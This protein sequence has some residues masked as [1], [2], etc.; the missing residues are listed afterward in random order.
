MATKLHVGNLAYTTTVE[1]LRA[2]FSE[3]G[4]NV[5]SVSMP[6]S[7]K[8]GEPRGFAFVQMATEADAEAAVAALHLR[9]IDGRQVKVQESR[10]RLRTA[11]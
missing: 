5:E 10:G 4:R 11:R 8:D 7:M 9:E 2:A 1:A 3:G 6:T